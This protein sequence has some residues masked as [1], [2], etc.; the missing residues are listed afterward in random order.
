MITGIAR[1]CGHAATPARIASAERGVT[2]I[3]RETDIAVAIL[4]HSKSYYRSIY[5]EIT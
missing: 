2:T 3:G 4:Q 1:F 5:C